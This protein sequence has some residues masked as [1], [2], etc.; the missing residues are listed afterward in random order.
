MIWFLSDE[1]DVFQDQMYNRQKNR[2]IAVIPKDV[3]N[4]QVLVFGFRCCLQQGRHYAPAHVGGRVKGHHQHLPPGHGADS[5]ALDLEV[6]PESG[7]RALPP[8]MRPTGLWPGS[9]STGTTSSPRSNGLPA[10]PT[11]IRWIILFG[12]TFRHIPFDIPTPIKPVCNCI[13][14]G[15]LHD[16][17]P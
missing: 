1:I 4:N 16:P 10:A 8:A 15:A 11:L 3:P 17:S 12:A 7:R 6:I 2:W 14:I 5:V 13:Q 9:R